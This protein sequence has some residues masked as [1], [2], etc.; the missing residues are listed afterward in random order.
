MDAKHIEKTCKTCSASH[1]NTIHRIWFVCGPCRV[2]P[3][4]N[5]NWQKPVVP[6]EHNNQHAE[7]AT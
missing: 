1:E 5:S 4:R 7:G 6:N 2:T 3:N